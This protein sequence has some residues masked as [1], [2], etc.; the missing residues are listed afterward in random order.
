[1]LGNSGEIYFPKLQQDQ[2][3]TFAEI[4]T[5]F[6]QT[7]GYAVV[8]CCSEEEAK[9][10]ARVHLRDSVS[11]EYHVYYFNSD[12]TGEKPYEEFFTDTELVNRDQF[13]SLGVITNAPKRPI[14]EIDALFASLEDA[15]SHS[16][17]KEDVVRIMKDFLKNFDHH[18]TG[19]YLDSKM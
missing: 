9:Q 10:K 4:S 15:F 19:K 16:C 11:H 8:E 5:R 17:S 18:E 6:L 13:K 2:M 3:L 1:M 12:T 14:S 7:H